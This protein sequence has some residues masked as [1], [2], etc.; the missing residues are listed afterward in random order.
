MPLCFSAGV[1]SHFKAAVAEVKFFASSPRLVA[2]MT[3]NF[4]E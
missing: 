4:P 3:P 1:S 2:T